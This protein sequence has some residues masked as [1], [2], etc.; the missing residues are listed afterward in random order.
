M[1]VRLRPEP[2]DA[3]VVAASSA[4]V[5]GQ[6]ESV[7]VP[8]SARLAPTSPYGV[9]KLA[10]D[11]YTRLFADL[12][13]L[14]TVTLRYFNVYG[15]RQT[16]SYSGVISTFFEQA[17]AGVPLTVQGDGSQTRDFV[18]VSDIVAANLLAAATEYTGEVF[19]VGTGTETRIDELAR[20][21]IERTGSNADVRYVERRPGDV[22]RS[23]AA[24]EKATTLLGYDPAVE[25]SDGLESLVPAE[26]P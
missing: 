3:R 26:H 19:N 1:V 15:P 14:P 12:Y 8:E 25:L 24:I 2:L 10:L 9:D 4:A 7:P 21:I 16:A 5:Y 22:R 17:A 6:P 13:G 23:C 11:A 20:L 18:H